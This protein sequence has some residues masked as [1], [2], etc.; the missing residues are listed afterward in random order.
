MINEAI[1][2]IISKDCQHQV[3]S[4]YQ[5]N[6]QKVFTVCQSEGPVTDARSIYESLKDAGLSFKSVRAALRKLNEMVRIGPEW[7]Q[8]FYS[9]LS[10]PTIIWSHYCPV[11]AFITLKFSKF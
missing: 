1:S 9:L 2:E 4:A 6:L 11:P 10:V 7:N 5:E 3:P 8:I